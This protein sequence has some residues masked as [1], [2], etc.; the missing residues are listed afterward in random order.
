MKK[1]CNIIHS[2]C[3]FVI[4]AGLLVGHSS[5]LLAE[6]KSNLKPKYQIDFKQFVTSNKFN[7]QSIGDPVWSVT[8]DAIGSNVLIQIPIRVIHGDKPAQVSSSV[9][10]VRDGKFI[11]AYVP[12]K[13][14]LGKSRSRRSGYLNQPRIL[15]PQGRQ[16]RIS[17]NFNLQTPD[18]KT[19]KIDYL[20]LPYPRVSKKV[21]ITLDGKAE[22]DLPR[23]FDYLEIS[24]ENSFYAM[25]VDRSLLA[26]K[27]PSVRNPTSPRTRGRTERQSTKG[28]SRAEKKELRERESQDRKRKKDEERE[29]RNVKRDYLTLKSQVAKVPTEFSQDDTEVVWLVY[30]VPADLTEYEITVTKHKKWK[31]SKD[32]L[33]LA[34]SIAK[35]QAQDI[36][37]TITESS[38]EYEN[39]SFEVLD[40]VYK[41]SKGDHPNDLSLA[42]ASIA[43]NNALAWVD[44]NGFTPRIAK[45]ALEGENVQAISLLA[46]GLAGVKEQ[47]GTS[48]RFT[49]SI[50]R[51]Y[52]KVLDRKALRHA[53]VAV[54]SISSRATLQ[55]ISKLGLTVKGFLSEKGGPDVDVLLQSLLDAWD[56]ARGKS[57][58]PQPNYLKEALRL[59]YVALDMKEVVPEKREEVIDFITKTAGTH[60]LPFEWINEK[61][62]MTNDNEQLKL[63]LGKIAALEI[64]EFDKENDPVFGMPV[65][66]NRNVFDDEN[67]TARIFIYSVRHPIFNLL[68]HDDAKINTLA[69]KALPNFSLVYNRKMFENNGGRYEEE[70]YEKTSV[71]VYRRFVHLATSDITKQ[72]TI[73]ELIGNQKGSSQAIQTL[74]NLGSQITGVNGQKAASAFWDIG[75]KFGEDFKKLAPM[76]QIRLMQNLYA[77]KKIAPPHTISYLRLSKGGT[78]I[79]EWLAE[80][81]FKQSLPSYAQWVKAAGGERILTRGMLES[82]AEVAD[83]SAKALVQLAGGLESDVDKIKAKINGVTSSDEVF[84]IWDEFKQKLLVDSLKRHVGNYTMYIKGKKKTRRN[85]NVENKELDDKFRSEEGISLGKYKLELSSEQ[86]KFAGVDAPLSLGEE[87]LAI[88][89]ENVRNIWTWKKNYD[90]LKPLGLSPKRQ[91]IDLLPRIDGTWQGHVT[92]DDEVVEMILVPTKKLKD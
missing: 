54:L 25:K 58:T 69:W 26:K 63:T 66:P 11:T 71:H 74:M 30:S 41:L 2:I 31:I 17:R 62:L 52:S 3:F 21:T 23:K 39:T 73:F 50:L 33:D 86:L 70:N 56:K 55:D 60:L 38:L 19:N 36:D 92:F 59:L 4:Y 79:V 8:R 15:Q 87:Q 27:D 37:P 68:K 61:L 80:L 44:N 88:R 32:N 29:L 18:P 43:F 67:K 34:M 85:N 9:C 81:D 45:Q 10:K 13:Q 47:T 65:F 5:T 42:I 90:L 84:E 14:E 89:I 12:T 16:N 28:L 46:Q 20:N 91:F 75:E 40:Q 51:D 7:S 53:N 49:E 77:S 24:D 6:D 78:K 82:N 83:D 35:A 64:E 72:N 1:H 57:G 48:I 76:Q 22:W